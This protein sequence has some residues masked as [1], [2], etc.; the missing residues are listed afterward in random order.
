MI[1]ALLFERKQKKNYSQMLENPSQKNS[2]NQQ[3]TI[4]SSMKGA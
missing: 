2:K 1:F 4:D 3:I